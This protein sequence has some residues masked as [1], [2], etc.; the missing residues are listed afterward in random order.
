[1]RRIDLTKD[2]RQT[3]AKLPPKHARQIAVKISAL[4]GDPLSADSQVL[5][6]HAPHRRADQGEYRIIY[7]FDENTLRVAL[8]GK[9]NDDEVY[10]RFER[11]V[12]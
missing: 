12:K 6:G 3:L 1:M 10:K 11:K 7:D 9:R 4:A 8:V 5:K 2:A